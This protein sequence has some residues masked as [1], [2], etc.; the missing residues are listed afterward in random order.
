MADII[1]GRMMHGKTY[2]QARDKL[3]AAAAEASEVFGDDEL[4]RYAASLGGCC[5]NCGR[6]GPNEPVQMRCVECKDLTAKY[7]AAI[8]K[9]WDNQAIMIR[10]MLRDRDVMK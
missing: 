10:G 8:A 4:E 2:E 1:T 5:D 7:D 3:I 9:G 6:S